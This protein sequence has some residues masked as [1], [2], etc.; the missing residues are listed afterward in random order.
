M[1]AGIL[2][3]GGHVAARVWPSELP[4]RPLVL[5]SLMSVSRCVVD[6]RGGGVLPVRLAVADQPADQEEQ[7]KSYEEIMEILEAFD[8][9]R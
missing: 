8:L 4:A 9:T 2:P 6:C 1:I 5:P 7:V 3:G